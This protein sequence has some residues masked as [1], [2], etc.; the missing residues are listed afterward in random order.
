[1]THYHIF[2]Q[3]WFMTMTGTLN[4]RF[5]Y[6]S[7]IT[8]LTVSSTI[9]LGMSATAQKGRRDSR[10]RMVEP[11]VYAPDLYADNLRMKF[12]LVNLP[13]SAEPESY[14]EISY[15]LYFIPEA[16]YREETMRQTRAA[17]SAAGPPQYP[18]QVLLAKGEFK[19]KDI[20]TLKDR[21]HVLNAVRFKS[22]VPNRERTKFAVLMTVY[23]VKIYDARLKTTAYH[24]SYFETHPFADDPARPQTAVPRA[25]IYTSFYLSPKGNIWGSQLPREGNDPNW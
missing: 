16:S 7:F 8:L 10:T 5:I 12:T 6:A 22:K 3:H 23:S 9:A 18:G 14:W 21:T 24:S 15:R 4:N 25:T 20:D 13:G 17:R 11:N 1:M 2:K 19:K